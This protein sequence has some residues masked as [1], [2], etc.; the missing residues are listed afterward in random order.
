LAKALGGNVVLQRSTLGHGS[1]FKIAIETGLDTPA[2][3]LASLSD[4]AAGRLHSALE[5]ATNLNGKSILLVEDVPDNRLLVRRLLQESGADVDLAENGR[6]GVR[7]ALKKP[8]DVVLMDLQMPELDGFA[9]ATTLRDRG[10]F[11][12]IIALSAYAMKED[13]ERALRAGC[14]EHLVKPIN[15]RL[16]IERVAAA[17]DRTRH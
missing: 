13:R 15:S 10:Y 11:G 6:D 9:A 12:P 14:D 2:S 1:T 8:Y 5:A 3:E 16:L 7:Q 4:A 17:A